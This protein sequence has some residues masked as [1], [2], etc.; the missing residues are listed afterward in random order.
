MTQLRNGNLSDGDKAYL[1]QLVATNTNMSQSDAAKRVDDVSN[2]IAQVQTKLREEADAARNAAAH[3]AFYFAFSLFV[4]AFIGGVAGALGG[5]H[6]E[7]HALRT[8][9]TVV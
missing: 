7:H 1:A 5:V 4:W 8:R 6:R 2:Q 9:R 3:A